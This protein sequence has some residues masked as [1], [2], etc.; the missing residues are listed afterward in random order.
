MIAILIVLAVVLFIALLRFGVMVRYCENGFYIWVRAGFLSFQILPPKKEKVKKV[1]KVK[2]KK[3][4]TLDLKPG[5]LKELLDMLPPIKNTL[6]RIRRRLLIK[7][8]EL[9]YTAAGSDP[10][11]VAMTFGTANAVIS[12]LVP[13]LE[14]KFRIK[15]SDIRVSADFESTEQKIYAN[16]AISLA[17]WEAL[18]IAFALLPLLKPKKKSNVNEDKSLKRKEVKE[19][20]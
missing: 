14:E 9:Y 10:S 4:S 7:R 19:N 16:L 5:S 17:V 18:Y 8:L 6:S 20:E 11:S 3:E 12:M 15:H 2:K 13:F 1:K